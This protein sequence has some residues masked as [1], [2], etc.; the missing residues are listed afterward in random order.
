MA[1]K[2][3]DKASSSKVSTTD[4]TKLLTTSQQRERFMEFFYKKNL[5][6]PKYGKLTTFSSECFDFP[7]LF[8]VQKI[9]DFVTDAGSYYPDLV[10]AF[11]GNMFFENNVLTSAVKGVPISLTIPE[12]GKCLKIAFEGVE[13]RTSHDPQLRDYVKK[14]FYYNISRISE[15]AFIEK[16]RKTCGRLPDKPFWS[17]GNLTL[18]DRIL[19]YF[20]CYVLV[21]KASNLASITN[22]EMQ[23][24][25][26]VKNKI[27]V[28]WASV[29]L[30][31]MAS[32]SEKSASLSYARLLT[33]VFKKFKVN[34]TNE[35]CYKM[36]EADCEISTDV[37]TTK[38]GVK[39]QLYE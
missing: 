21:S 12:F 24:M 19:H 1:T 6:P 14:D 35:L 17:A 37:I 9:H 27:P 4:L 30:H 31:H 10:K 3:K 39:F 29:I 11:Y 26:A 23:L 15:R 2:R 18:D 38:M 22:P 32:H 36:S 20:L 28:N 33:K 16:R 13:I 25:Y 34:V 5:T 8:R 7:Q